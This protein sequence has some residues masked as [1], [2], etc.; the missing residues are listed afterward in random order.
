MRIRRRHGIGLGGYTADPASVRVPP[1][2]WSAVGVVAVSDGI[3]GIAS[4]V[5]NFSNYQSK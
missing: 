3:D 4:M 2:S 1:G 5:V